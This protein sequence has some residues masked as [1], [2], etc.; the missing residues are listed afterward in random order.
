MANKYMIVKVNEIVDIMVIAPTEKQL[1]AMPNLLANVTIQANVGKDSI[2]IRTFRLRTMQTKKVPSTT[3]ITLGGNGYYNAK[4]EWK[5]EVSI[6][7]DLY[8]EIRDAAVAVVDSWA[9]YDL[10]QEQLAKAK[11][12]ELKA[13]EEAAAKEAK[14]AAAAAKRKATKVDAT[15]K[16]KTKK[17]AAK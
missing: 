17:A 1:A 5:D 16:A 13:A 10:E 9:A 14:K 12:E 6:T 8:S 2:K 15:T 4:K 3:F 11:E 7:K